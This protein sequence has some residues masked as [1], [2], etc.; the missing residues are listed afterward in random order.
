MGSSDHILQKSSYGVVSMFV[1]LF[2]IIL[3]TLG[4]GSL[5]HER[6]YPVIGYTER[7]VSNDLT[8]GEGE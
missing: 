3:S 8:I 7:L 6:G 4:A 1:P 2:Y 5:I